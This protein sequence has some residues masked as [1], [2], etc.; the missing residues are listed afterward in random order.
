MAFEMSRMALAVLPLTLLGSGAKGGGAPIDLL[1]GV[2]GR[3]LVRGR[4]DRGLFL[5]CISRRRGGVKLLHFLLAFGW[6][7]MPG[8]I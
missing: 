7:R 1:L 4:R 5:I 8:L 2:S 3:S 6:M